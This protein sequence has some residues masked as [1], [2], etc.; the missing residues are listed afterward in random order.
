MMIK[1][2]NLIRGFFQKQP[3]VGAFTKK[4]ERRS[5]VESDFPVFREFVLFFQVCF[6]RS[7][8]NLWSTRQPVKVTT[9]FGGWGFVEGRTREIR[10]NTRVS[11]V[12]ADEDMGFTDVCVLIDGS[13]CLILTATGNSLSGMIITE[14]RSYL[15]EVVGVGVFPCTTLGEFN[16]LPDGVKRVLRDV[17]QV[18]VDR[19]SET[20][21]KTIDP[22]ERLLAY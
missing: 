20:K 3:I 1:L 2:L 12:E 18:S 6:D 5:L 13:P 16:T 7:S 21:N 11:L 14:D 17:I 15:Q 9:K 10:I 4:N 19:I 22:V 8:S